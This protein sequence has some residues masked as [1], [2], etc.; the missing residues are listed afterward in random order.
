MSVADFRK[1]HGLGNDYLVMEPHHFTSPITPE[2]AKRICDRHRGIGADG[3]LV[4]PLFP[5][6]G[7]GDGAEAP[8]V[9]IYNPDGSSSEKSGNGLRIFA[10]FLWERGYARGPSIAIATA[11][12]RVLAELVGEGAHRIAVQMGRVTFA[13]RDIPMTGPDREVLGESLE[14]EGRTI[15]IHAAAIGNPHCVVLVDKPSEEL[16]R[17]LGPRIENHPSF[18]HRTNVQFMEVVDEHRVAI[19]IWERGVGRTLASGTSSCAAAAVACR[20]GRCRSP[21]TVAMAGGELEVTFDENFGARLE[22]D[23][24]AVGGGRFSEEFL[25]ELGLKRQED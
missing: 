16:T 2:M 17:E 7:A 9:T 19:E 25:A 15:T 14:L 1:Y 6:S 13:S 21:V 22:G 3:L 23:V 10:R 20:L 8:G 4:G 5:R 24:A 12:G 11:G 18:P